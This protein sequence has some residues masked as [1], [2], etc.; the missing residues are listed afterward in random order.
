M[1]AFAS[2]LAAGMAIALLL[3]G[4]A[5]VS[6]AA[7]RASAADTARYLAGMPVS[8]SSPLTDWTGEEAWRQHAGALDGA[9]QRLE[10]AQLAP[11]RAWTDRTIPVQRPTLLYLFSGPDYLYANAFFPAAQTYVMA[12]LEPVGPV[13]EVTAANRGSLGRLRNAIGS[14]LSMSFFRTNSMRSD[15]QTGTFNGTLPVIYL[16]LARAGRT[17][18][19]TTLVRL[20]ATGTIVPESDATARNQP[21]GARVTFSGSDGV[22]RELYYFQVDVSNSGPH[23]EAFMTFCRGLGSADAFLKSASYLLHSDSFS[24]VRGL[25]LEAQLILQDDSGIPLRA[26]RDDEWQLY[27]FGRYVGPIG[28]FANRYQSSLA[29]LFRSEDAEPIAFGVGYRFRRN[30]SNLLL[31]VKRPM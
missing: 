24:R 22:K 27:P 12:G 6:A 8:K 11:I 7:Q 30:E 2:R 15:L 25:L 21:L 17:V 28:L 31:A 23:L 20:S 16:F 19:E 13:P 18:E 26:F 9:F 3:Q 5:A 10:Q 29:E 1:I 4:L 14:V